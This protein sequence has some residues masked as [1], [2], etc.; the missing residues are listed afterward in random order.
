MAMS[1]L[2][3]SGYSI[4]DARYWMLD[5]GYS[6]LDTRYWILDTGYSILVTGYWFPGYWSLEKNGSGHKAYGPAVV[7]KNGTM[8]GKQG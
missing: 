8:A 2:L 4:L 6:I 5:T 7:L 1:R 3:D